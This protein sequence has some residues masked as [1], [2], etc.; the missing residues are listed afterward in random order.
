MSWNSCTMTVEGMV[1][2]RFPVG[3]TD[4]IYSV[5]TRELGRIRASARGALR[6]RNPWRGVLEPFYRIQAE[7]FLAPGSA[8]HRF[9][10]A[11]IIGRPPAWIQDLDALQAAYVVI[12]ILDRFTPESVPQAELFDAAMQAF[13]GIDE[14]PAV[15]LPIVLC[16]C[17]RFLTLAGFAVQWNQCTACSKSRPDRRSAYFSA[18]T[19]GILCSECA[20]RDGSLQTHVL[21]GS[22]VEMA[23]AAGEA[24]PLPCDGNRLADQDD[25]TR[26]IMRVIKE[27][28]GHH[29]GDVPRALSMIQTPGNDT[30]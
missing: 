6:P 20:A 29:L 4:Q 11:R 3:E 8:L 12:E 24:R 2:R 18:G 28:F 15:A 7:L 27:M 23:R 1:L 10:H 22:V 13:G 26:Q 5:I 21:T 25:F 9:Q 19:G 14:A 30:V 17:L 16:F